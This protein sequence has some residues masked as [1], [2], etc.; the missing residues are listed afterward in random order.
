MLLVQEQGRVQWQKMDGSRIARTAHEPAIGYHITAIF[1]F[2]TLERTR[3]YR[4][5][6][7]DHE[8]VETAPIDPVHPGPDAC[9][10]HEKLK[11]AGGTPPDLGAS[12]SA[13]PAKAAVIR[14]AAP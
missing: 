10:A 4:N 13:A 9:E 2:A 8:S 3:I 6:T 14:P 5:I 7:T 1:N 11:A 12:P